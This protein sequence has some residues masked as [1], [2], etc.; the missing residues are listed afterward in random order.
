MSR[1]SFLST[2]VI[3]ITAIIDMEKDPPVSSNAK[4]NFA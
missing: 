2:L 4:Y 3:I 1:S